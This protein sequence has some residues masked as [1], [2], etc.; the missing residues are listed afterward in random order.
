MAPAVEPEPAEEEEPEPA[1]GVA[2]VAGGSEGW[3]AAFVGGGQDDHG[4]GGDAGGGADALQEGL[5]VGRAG[6]AD[7]EQVA[8]VAGD[9]VAGLDLDDVGEAVGGVVG[10]AR[11]DRGDRDE[12]GQGQSDL[13]GVD[14]RR[15]GG[16]DAA[17]L[18]AADALMDGGDRQAG[19]SAEVSETHAPISAQ[20]LHDSSVE[21]F[22]HD[23]E[24]TQV[25]VWE[26]GCFWSVA[27][28]RWDSRY[29]RRRVC[30]R[31]AAGAARECPRAPRGECAGA[32]GVAYRGLG[33]GRVGRGWEGRW[34]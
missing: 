10:G 12:G 33:F 28:S 34:R 23:P 30:A 7:L 20:H 31:V 26:R 32:R 1:V 22:Q 8:F 3:W 11:V 2:L 5:Q 18:Q 4:A 29:G 6:D 13:G 9:A 27:W 24:R 19:G 21:I 14:E 15:V 25:T 16:D 17:L